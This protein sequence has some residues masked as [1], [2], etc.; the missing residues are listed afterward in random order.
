MSLI[1]KAPSLLVMFFSSD[2]V[3]LREHRS[4]NIA[5]NAPKLFFASF[6]IGATTQSCFHLEARKTLYLRREASGFI[7]PTKSFI[8]IVSSGFLL[9]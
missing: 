9:A 1:S 6:A 5:L 8:K 4:E 2:Q 3:A 7:S